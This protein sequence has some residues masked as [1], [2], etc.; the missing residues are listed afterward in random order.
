MYHFCIFLSRKLWSH[1]PSPL[2]ISPSPLSP[3]VS[4][5]PL[6]QCVHQVR[7]VA[8][9]AGF[10]L[11]A[12]SLCMCMADKYMC[13]CRFGWGRLSR[14]CRQPAEKQQAR[15]AAAAKQQQHQVTVLPPGRCLSVRC[16]RC[17]S[18]NTSRHS[19]GEKGL[20]GFRGLGGW[21]AG[22]RGGRCQGLER[23]A[24][25]LIA[26]WVWVCGVR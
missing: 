12:M 23:E 24:Q 26:C 11:L 9:C 22:F 2:Y 16:S 19:H 5:S 15:M 1:N 18:A 17:P 7:S 3:F 4:L 21:C 20:A 10:R 25:T 6:F 13:V 8:N 14:H